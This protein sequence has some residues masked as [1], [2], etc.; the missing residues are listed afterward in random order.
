MDFSI[1]LSCFLACYSF[2]YL[3]V[4]MHCFSI[5]LE[6]R[7]KLRFSVSV[8]FGWI[9]LSLSSDDHCIYPLPFVSSSQSPLFLS[10]TLA[11]PLMS[12]TGVLPG[13]CLN[14]LGPPSKPASA[15]PPPPPFSEKTKRSV[16][17]PLSSHVSPFFS[18]FSPQQGEN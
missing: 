2:F 12:M 1:T 11:C 9:G 16:L 13:V 8:F 14:S 6:R 10:S 18:P 5:S 4:F 17:P 15:L 7:R 3:T